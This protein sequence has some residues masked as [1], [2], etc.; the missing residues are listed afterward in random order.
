MKNYILS[1]YIGFAAMVLFSCKKNIDENIRPFNDKADTELLTTLDGLSLATNGNYTLLVGTASDIQYDVSWFNVSELKGNNLFSVVQAY[2]ETRNDSYIFKNSPSQGATTS[3]WRV[4]YRLIFGTNKVIDAVKDGVDAAHDQV[5]GENYFL[6]ALAYFNLVRVY[7]RPY[8]QNNGES[9]AVPLSLNSLVSKDYQPKRNTVK[10]VYAQ[11]ISDLEKAATLMTQTR[12]N[13]YASREAAWALLSRVYLY[14]GG[15]PGAPQNANNAKAVEYADK[16]IT[17][18]KYT[19]ITGTAYSTSFASDSKANKEFIFSFRHDDANGNYIN[20]FLTPRDV[21]GNPYQGEYSASPDYMDL[22]KQ[23]PADLRMNFI[24]VE[25]DKRITT[26]DKTRYSVNKYNY[27]QIAPVGGFDFS[28]RSRSGTAY[29]RLAELYLNK[30]EA[31]AK[32]G[33]NTD[34]LIAL[35]AVRVRANAPGW[36]TA[37]LATAG[38]TV[39]QAVLNERRLELAWE[40][41]SSFDNFR[42]GLPMIRKYIDYS[43]TT[44]LTIQPDD[45]LVV[46]PLPLIEIQLNPNLDQNPL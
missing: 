15:T 3:F 24:T 45:K 26:T 18:N 4:S 39:F 38:L 28:A 46:Y 9:L 27:Q 43:V 19:L 35:N 30:A 7:G 34:A 32:S 2:P 40:G 36:T 8:Y 31:L 23:N 33:N 44:P 5:K 17:S 41:H 12:G 37:T 10:E 16:V 1:I 21:F 6:R 14:M 42:N 29:L 20:E 25:N 22:L 11:V 13:N